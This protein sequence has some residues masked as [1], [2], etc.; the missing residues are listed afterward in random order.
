MKKVFLIVSCMIYSLGYSQGYTLFKNSFVPFRISLPDNFNLVKNKIP[1]EI[2]IFFIENKVKVPVLA[3]IHVKDNKFING[4]KKISDRKI[5]YLKSNYGK[6]KIDKI[7]SYLNSVPK[8]GN[9]FIHGRN[10][11]NKNLF[12]YLYSKEYKGLTEGFLLLANSNCILG[13]LK[14]FESTDQTPYFF[15]SYFIKNNIVN[16]QMYDEDY[17]I[18]DGTDNSKSFYSILSISKKGIITNLNEEKSIEFI[19]ENKQLIKF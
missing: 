11:I 1:I 2:N 3:S 6:K 9:A 14:V 18:D 4:Q 7:Y 17:D 16:V 5:V 10:K 12:L 8:K 19:E 13:Y 15:K